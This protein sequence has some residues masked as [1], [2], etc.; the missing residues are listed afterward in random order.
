[1]AKVPENAM[2]EGV[3]LESEAWE[4]FE[5]VV[6]Q[7]MKAP[8]DRDKEK[9]QSHATTYSRLSAQSLP[10]VSAGNANPR[11]HEG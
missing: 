3:E 6:D 4:R 1:M 8:M 2:F 9:Q 10:S 11:G 7:V 5:A